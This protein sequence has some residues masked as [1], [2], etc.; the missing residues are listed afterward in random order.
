MVFLTP[1]SALA[2]VSPHCSNTPC[3]CPPREGPEAQ[4]SAPTSPFHPAPPTAFGSHGCQPKPVFLTPCYSPRKSSAH[5]LPTG[6]FPQWGHLWLP[7]LNSHTQLIARSCSRWA[8]TA[9]LTF[10]SPHPVPVLTTSAHPN[11]THQVHAQS[12]LPNRP[13]C[14]YPL[15]K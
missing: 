1:P 10:L 5:H 6:S 7:S 15:L 13:L 12:S 4:S 2:S 11:D 14:N 3:R 9:R 8:T